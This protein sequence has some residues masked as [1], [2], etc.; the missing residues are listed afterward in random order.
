MRRHILRELNI[1]STGKVAVVIKGKALVSYAEIKYLT[2][3]VK[4]ML[5]LLTC[6]IV[7]LVSLKTEIIC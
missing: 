7:M 4:G 5:F 6:F 2:K 3:L 1:F